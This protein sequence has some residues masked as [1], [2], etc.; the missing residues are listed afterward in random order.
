MV[1]W[2]FW[3]YIHGL[4]IEQ[5]TKVERPDSEMIGLVLNPVSSDDIDSRFKLILHFAT[6][7]NSYK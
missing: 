3:I 1:G 6:N 2:G 4:T 5:R 7:S